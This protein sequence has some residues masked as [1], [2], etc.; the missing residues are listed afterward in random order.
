[1][2]PFECPDRRANIDDKKTFCIPWNKWTNCLERGHCTYETADE[3]D[4]VIDE[5]DE[6]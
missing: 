4:V 6:D 3:A 2:N 5:E 1:M